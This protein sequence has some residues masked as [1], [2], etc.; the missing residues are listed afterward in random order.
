MTSLFIVEKYTQKTPIKFQKLL[1]SEKKQAKIETQIDFKY[2]HVVPKKVTVVL[3]D[4][5]ESSLDN[6]ERLPDI[7]E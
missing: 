2:L 3:P 5:D 7:S 1:K 6:I 4:M